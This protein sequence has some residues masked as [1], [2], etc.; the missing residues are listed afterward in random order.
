M[1]R[2]LIKHTDNFFYFVY[3]SLTAG[4]FSNGYNDRWRDTESNSAV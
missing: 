2:Y 4:L 3:A 1:S